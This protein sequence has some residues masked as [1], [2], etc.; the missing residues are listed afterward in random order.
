[1]KQT[2]EMNGDAAG[3][4]ESV[5]LLYQVPTEGTTTVTGLLVSEGFEVVNV[6]VGREQVSAA[7]AVGKV[8]PPGSYLIVL[9]KNVTEDTLPAKGACVLEG[10]KLPEPGPLGIK[11]LALPVD[12]KNGVVQD[13]MQVAMSKVVTP[14]HTVPTQPAPQP[15]PAGIVAGPNEVVILLSRGHAE[16]LSRCLKTN[17]PPH[18]ATVSDVTRRIDDALRQ[19]T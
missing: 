17:Y 12:T 13:E 3:P 2:Y 8:A 7:D 15:R 11:P 4:G 6:F 16:E 1:M 5:Q 19:Q 9:A 10:D 14:I 18:G